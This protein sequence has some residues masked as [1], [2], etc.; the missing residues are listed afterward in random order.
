MADAK[1]SNCGNWFSRDGLFSSSICGACKRAGNIAEEARAQDAAHQ[2]NMQSIAAASAIAQDE[3]ARQQTAAAMVVAAKQ[4]EAAER[5]ARAAEQVAAAQSEAA[6]SQARAAL[7]QAV[8]SL[9]DEGLRRFKEQEARDTDKKATD[10]VLDKIGAAVACIESEGKSTD[11]I[12]RNAYPTDQS[13]VS[14]ANGLGQAV[15]WHNLVAAQQMLTEACEQ[16]VRITHWSAPISRESCL[17]RA[18][19]FIQTAKKSRTDPPVPMTS[20]TLPPGNPSADGRRLDLSSCRNHFEFLAVTPCPR[21]SVER[22]LWP[23]QFS[24]Q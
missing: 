13:N 11:K 16:V 24:R 10:D 4:F 12:N 6:K 21:A 19:R 22:A 3:Q 8:G 17:E 5:Q 9:D 7:A 18:E 2:G 20:E 23:A 14:N 1:C 15:S